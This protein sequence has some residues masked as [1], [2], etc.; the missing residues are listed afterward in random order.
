MLGLRKTAGPEG[1]NRAELQDDLM[2]FEGRFAARLVTAFRPLIESSDAA[3]R[4][5]AARDELAFMSSALDIAVGSAPE[6]DLLDMYT[7]VSLGRD[8]MARRW[9]VATWGESAHRVADAFRASAEDISAI[10]AAVVSS[11]VEAELRQVIVQWQEENRDQDDVAGVRLSE[12]AKFRAG[13]TASSSG[14]FA[15]LRSASQTADTAVLLGDRALYASQRMPFVVG[16]NARIV[17]SEL[18]SE[19]Q[20]AIDRTLLKAVLSLGALAVVGVVVSFL[21]AKSGLRRQSSH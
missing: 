14:I 17:G 20:R 16:L 1:P 11:S 3:S 5:R 2:R 8:A 13:S 18:V 19:A 9:D 21:L 15:I 6:V 4:L 12:Y 10:A 7:L